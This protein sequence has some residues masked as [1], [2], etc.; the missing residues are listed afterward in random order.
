MSNRLKVIIGVQALC[1]CVLMFGDI[2]FDHPGK[3]GLDFIHGILIV[4]VYAALL[5][6]GVALAIV[7]RRWVALAIQAVP[8]VGYL[9]YVSAPL[10]TYHA[11]EYTSL[12]GRSRQDVERKL[13]HPRGEL[14]G[15]LSDERHKDVEFVSLRGMTIFIGRDD[16]VVSVEPNDR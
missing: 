12:V 8:I 14:R 10:P 3:Y 13:G 4:G 7:R 2:G 5:I 15:A 9:A 16:V 11:S 6:S 1:W